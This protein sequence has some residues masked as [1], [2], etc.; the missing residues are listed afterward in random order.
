MIKPSEYKNILFINPPLIGYG[1]NSAGIARLRGFLKS[2][3]I[4]SS[5]IDLNTFFYDRRKNNSDFHAAITEFED[6]IVKR[7]SSIK[8]MYFYLNESVR[9]PTRNILLLYIKFYENDLWDLAKKFH[10]ISFLNEYFPNDLNIDYLG[11]SVAYPSQFIFTLILA[12]YIKGKVKKDIKIILGGYSISS[13]INKLKIYFKDRPIIDY[14]IVGEGQTAFYELVSGKKLKFVKNLV[15]FNGSYYKDSENQNYIEDFNTL[16]PPLYEVG[17]LPGIQAASGCYWNKCTFCSY[18]LCKNKKITI[19]P[20]DDV[21]SD[22][23]TIH[24]SLKDPNALY[25]FTDQATPIP[26]FIQFLK[27]IQTDKS[28]SSNY[29]FYLRFE[30]ELSRD[31]LNL[32]KKYVFRDGNSSQIIFG[33]ESTNPRL[34]K[35]MNKGIDIKIA[36]R[37]MR[38]CAEL[39]INIEIEL[40]LGF[41]TQTAEDFFSDM[42][43]CVNIIKKYPNPNNINF[44]IHNFKVFYGT[45]IYNKPQK[46]GIELLKNKK[47]LFNIEIPYKQLNIDTLSFSKIM[48]AASEFIKR[49]SPE[50][51]KR[52]QWLLVPNPFDDIFEK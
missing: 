6:Y 7:L 43:F 16:P 18:E 31:V 36:E 1:Y 48:D 22:I 25:Y 11:I 28:L 44:T 51:N 2:K 39:N 27:K 20:V 37:I 52:F 15:Y 8:G 50:I 14:M 46:Y 32:A 29:R 49:S 3:N 10:F 17:E 26:F 13:N 35:L 40:I 38:D 47:H 42:D 4:E 19:R 21:I 45:D 24:K 30:P 33:L 41:P 23:K 5:S 34:L 12:N 9:K